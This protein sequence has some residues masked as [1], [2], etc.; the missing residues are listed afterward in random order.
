[1]PAADVGRMHRWVKVDDWETQGG[2]R[3][4]IRSTKASHLRRLHLHRHEGEGQSQSDGWQCRQGA[5]TEGA[6]QPAAAGDALIKAGSGPQLMISKRR[7]QCTSPRSCR[8]VGP[9]CTACCCPAIHPAIQ[10]PEP[11]CS[12]GGPVHTPLAGRWAGLGA[13]T[14][15]LLIRAECTGR[16]DCFC[17][18]QGRSL[19]CA[20]AGNARPA[21]ALRPL[22]TDASNMGSGGMLLQEGMVVAF[23][24]KKF[25][26]ATAHMNKSCWL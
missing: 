4:R 19:L 17:G 25:S 23:T 21:K 22:I 6:R 10:T 12:K 3:G 15:P 11:S 13:H 1:M 26:N 16:T 9:R 8:L 7:V 18:S 14:C 20:H 24:S 2:C 5:N